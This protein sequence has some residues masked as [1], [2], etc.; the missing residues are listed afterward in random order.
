MT[1]I[2]ISIAVMHDRYLCCHYVTSKKVNCTEKKIS[3]ILSLP[4]LRLLLTKAK[5][6]K[7]FWKSK[8]C[9]V[10][11]HCI[12][13]T[14][15]SQMSTHL[16]GFNYF[17]G[18]LH[19][20]VLAKLANSSVRVKEFGVMFTWNIYHWTQVSLCTLPNH[21]N[22]AARTILTRNPS[23]HPNTHLQT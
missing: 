17:S 5:G 9:H 7:D 12:A 8:P 22:T 15:Y 4:M 16:P 14:E 21:Q 10:G 13:L 1:T 11:I 2:F 23:N 3:A 20:F 6:R 19:H 18:F